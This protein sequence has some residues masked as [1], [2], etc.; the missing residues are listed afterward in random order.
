[1]DR[2]TDGCMD[3]FQLGLIR[4]QTHTHAHTQILRRLSKTDVPWPVADAAVSAT[5]CSCQTERAS[6]RQASAAAETETGRRSQR[7]PYP[8]GSYGICSYKKNVD[9]VDR[10]L[11]FLQRKTTVASNPAAILIANYPSTFGSRQRKRKLNCL[12]HTKE[13]DK[14]ALI[15]LHMIIDV[16][17]S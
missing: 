12:F 14:Q 1:M 13:R 17:S 16:A 4:S 15:M 8:G 2:P 10:V 3:A 5:F 7:Y 9:S 11:R 6:P